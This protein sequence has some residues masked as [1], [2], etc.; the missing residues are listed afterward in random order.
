MRFSTNKPI[1][2]VSI[3]IGLLLLVVGCATGVG[4]A[5]L[6]QP[7]PAPYTPT[8]HIFTVTAVP[9]VV[10]EMQGSFDY[11]NTAFAKGGVLDGKEVY[12][13]SPSTLTVYAGDTINLS[14]VNPADDGHTFTIPDLKVNVEMQGQSVTKTS[15]VATKPGIYTFICD[16]AEHSPYMWGQ[17]VVLPDPT[18]NYPRPR[19][20]F[21]RPGA[22]A[23]VLSCA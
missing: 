2:A 12:G 18:S 11:L 17:L 13:F 5:A 6:S 23:P 16:E 15:F 14:L 7:A 10:H 8:T 22:Q 9:Q 19:A 21:P 1:S 3:L 20:P 4:A